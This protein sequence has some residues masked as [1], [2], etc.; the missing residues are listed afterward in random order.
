[1]ANLGM[2]YTVDALPD[3][4]DRTPIPA[5]VYSVMI[6]NAELKATIAGTGQYISVM[7]KVMEGPHTGRVV[8]DKIN[9]VNPNE[10]SQRIGLQALKKIMLAMGGTPITDSDQLIGARLVI[11]VG[12][13]KDA[14]YGDR[15]NVKDYQSGGGAI[16][17]VAAQPQPMNP[18]QAQAL[19]MAPQAQPTPPAHAQPVQH[20][21]QPVQQPVAPVQAQP[22]QYAPMPGY[23]APAPNPYAQAQAGAVP[24]PLPGGINP[25]DIPF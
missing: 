9:I 6:D 8:F 12:V 10:T 7:L 15:N 16:A 14:T 5:G 24:A 21:Q 4:E 11:K 17:P 13:E 2:T 18:V 22:Q 1:M 19:G 3:S 23:A 20:I 25:D